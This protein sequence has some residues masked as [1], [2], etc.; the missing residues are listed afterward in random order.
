MTNSK[1]RIYWLLL[2]VLVVVVVDE[3]LKAQAL[4]I[5]Q[6]ETPLVEPTLIDFTVHKNFGLAFDLP[7]RLEFVIAMTILIGVFLIRTAWKTRSSRPDIAFS[8]LVIILGA[9]GNFYDRIAYGFAVDYI[10][11]F[12]RSA[13]N[14]SD[15][16]IV[17]GVVALLIF[18][19]IHKPVDKPIEV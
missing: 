14:F 1:F 8:C 10:V 6:N 3:W 15:V 2:P 13:I 9:L 5:F 7:F 18:S 4:N 16:I 19:S 17:L 11:F 12:G